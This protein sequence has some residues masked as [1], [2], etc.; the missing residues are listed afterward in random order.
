MN[1][2]NACVVYGNADFC[3]VCDRYV[4]QKEPFLVICDYK[5]VKKCRKAVDLFLKYENLHPKPGRWKN[6]KLV[7]EWGLAGMRVPVLIYVC[8][9]ALILDWSII[10]LDK[11]NQVAYMSPLSYQNAQSASGMETTF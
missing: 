1:K 10:V 6:L 9:R 8:I 3:D 5:L 7:I 4:E 11:E 2:S